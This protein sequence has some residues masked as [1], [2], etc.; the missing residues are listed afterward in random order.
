MHLSF[1]LVFPFLV[2]YPK[3]TSVNKQKIFAYMCR[4]NQW[5]VNEILIEIVTHEGI[6]WKG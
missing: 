1:G 4:M 5:K 2:V 3:D 6:G